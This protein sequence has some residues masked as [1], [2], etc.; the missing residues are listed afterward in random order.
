MGHDVNDDT[1]DGD[2]DVGTGNTGADAARSSMGAI[3]G[4]G[5]HTDGLTA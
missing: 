1:R 2:N 4:R 3:V 5:C